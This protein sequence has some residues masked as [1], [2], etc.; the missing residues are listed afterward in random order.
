MPAP[1]Y[2]VALFRKIAANRDARVFLDPNRFDIHRKPNT[3]S[4][5]CGT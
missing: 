5:S 4:T 3:K 2:G 1:N